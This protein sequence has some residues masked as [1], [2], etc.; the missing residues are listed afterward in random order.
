MR[1]QK[2]PRLSTSCTLTSRV[3]RKEKLGL[4]LVRVSVRVRVRLKVRIRIRLRGGEGLCG[5]G[6][7]L[8]CA[9]IRVS[10]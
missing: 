4:G 5:G 10:T 6:L 3:T 7:R 2:V 8:T 9:R 1:V